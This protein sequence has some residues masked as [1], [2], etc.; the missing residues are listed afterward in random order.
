M[1]QRKDAN[2]ALYGAPQVDLTQFVAFTTAT[3]SANFNA[4]TNLLTLTSTAACWIALGAAPTAT[5]GA[6]S[7]YLPANF[8][9]QICVDHNTTQKLS[10]LQDSAG[11]NLSIIE[12]T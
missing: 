5:K 10:V 12:S 1:P 7:F 4:G 3:L 6:G 9:L 11:G 2:G 8:P